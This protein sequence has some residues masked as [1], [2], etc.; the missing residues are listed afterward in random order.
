MMKYEKKS[1][2]DLQCIKKPIANTA[3]INTFANNAPVLCS[4]IF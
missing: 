3:H 4:K 2:I 1:F